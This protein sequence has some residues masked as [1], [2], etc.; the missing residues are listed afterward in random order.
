MTPGPIQIR[1]AAALGVAVLLI[2]PIRSNAQQ[3]PNPVVA[4][5][6][7]AVSGFSGSIPPVQIAPGADPGQTTFIDVKGPSLRVIDLQHMNGPPTAQLVGALK[8]FTFSAATLGQVF[9]VALDDNSPPSIYAAASSSYGLPIVAPG[10]GGQPQHIKVGAANATFMPGLWGPQGGPGS[11]WKIDG[12]TG[13]VSLFAN[14]T[15]DGRTNSGPALGGLAY[16]ADSKALFVAD[17]ETGFVHGFAPDGHELARY[18]HGTAGRAAQGLPPVAWNVP[19]P[20]DVTGAQFDSGDPATWNYAAPE[21]RVFGLAVYQHRL[22]YA[23]ADGLQIW[24]VGLNADGTFADDAVIEIAVPPSAGPTEI[25][26]IAFDEQGRMFVADRPAPTGAFD[27]E[28]LTV[29]SIGR[30][31]RYAVVGTLDDGRRLW[32]ETPADYAIGF[33]RDLRNGNGG[34]AI[35]YRYDGKGDLLP[36]SCGG[37]VWS[38]GEDLRDSPDPTLAVKLKQSGPLNVDG[39]QGNETWRIRRDDEPPLVSYFIDYDDT[40]D[41]DGA[42][43]HLGDVAIARACLPLPATPIETY[44]TTPGGRP[45]GH[46]GAPP[47]VPGKPG[48]PGTPGTPPSCPPNQTRDP[49]SGTCGQ[50]PLRNVVINGRCCTVGSLVANAACSNS[51]CPAGQTAVGPSNFCCSNGQV[52]TGANGAP[53]CCS[54]NVVNGK[55]QPP[56]PPKSTCPSGYVTI[57]AACCLAGQV[58]SAGV[59]CPSGQTPSGPNKSQCLISIPPVL[60]GGPQCCSNGMIPVGAAHQCCAPANVTT[61]GVCCSGPVNPSNRASCPALKPTPACAGGYTKMSD[62]TCCNNRNITSDGK[63]CVAHEAPCAKGEFRDASGACVPVLSAPCA[64]DEVVDNN[65]SCVRRGPVPPSPPPPPPPG[66]T[67]P[68]KPA[69]PPGQMLNARGACVRAGGSLPPPRVAPPPPGP[70]PGAGRPAIR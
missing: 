14:V 69:C 46:A 62:G 4:L 42:R 17:R 23:V 32:Q 20:L 65:G 39:I 34:V 8:P 56:P 5:G 38:T 58:T 21:R 48:T 3:I 26:K 57:G 60:V 40:F 7:A 24:S 45:G 36:A 18:D 6:N 12:V 16:D 33:P 30:V 2:A 50:C 59:C 29:P 49:A 61:T 66:R 68:R 54:G 15:L 53:S 52:Y 27:F 55:C 10:P 37:F 43:G 70:R 9:G 47:W 51:N 25:S 67:Q 63:T 35:G 13:R 31:L 28:V 11:I 22:Y 64:P 19:P 44:P 41:E 1:L